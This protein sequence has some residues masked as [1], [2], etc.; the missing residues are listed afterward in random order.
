[1]RRI[2]LGITIVT[3]SL[4]AGCIQPDYTAEPPTPTLQ[5]GGALL[6]GDTPP[7]VV[8]T[9]EIGAQPSPTVIDQFVRGRGETPADLQIWYDQ[10]QGPD[11]LQGFS[12][13]NANGLPCAGF[14]LTALVG[15]VWQPNNGA[16]LCAPQADVNALA[17]V[18][19]FATTD[20]QPYTIVFG[21]VEDPTITAIAV[22]YSDGSNQ[23]ATPF[24]GGF[25]LVKAGVLS[26]N[27]ITA[28]NS[29]GNTIIPNI[30]Q[31]LAS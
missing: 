16:I 25:L 23:S 19:L 17:S 18:L 10:P 27:T 8:P 30:P 31:S 26:V 9:T 12:Y 20:G 11:Q 15:G 5:P 24:M 29:E 1:M 21:R 6:P 13:N 4:L 3:M 7:A 22:V 28:I 2:G 14:L